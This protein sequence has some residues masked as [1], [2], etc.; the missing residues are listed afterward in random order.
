LFRQH[1]GLTTVLMGFALPDDHIH[2]PNERLHI[3][4]W[5]RGIDTVIH[6]LARLA[7]PSVPGFRPWHRR[8]NPGSQGTLAA[9]RRRSA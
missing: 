7:E 8:E 4:T 1:L 3:P 5:Y 9:R 6:L 2:A